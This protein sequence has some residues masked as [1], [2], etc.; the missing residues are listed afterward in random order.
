MQ[1][2]GRLSPGAYGRALLVVSVSS[3]YGKPGTQLEMLEIWGEKIR[4]E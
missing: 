4:N 1:R 3:G 2:G